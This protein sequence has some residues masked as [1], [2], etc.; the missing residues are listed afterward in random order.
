MSDN[1]WILKLIAKIFLLVIA[2]VG[3][4]VAFLSVLWYFK[5]GGG[6]LTLL[7][8]FAV[9]LGSACAAYYALTF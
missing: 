9:F 5:N 6:N 3:V 8:C 7:L 2:L 4:V 1:R